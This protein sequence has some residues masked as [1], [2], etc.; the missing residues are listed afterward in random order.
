MCVQWFADPY[1]S[2]GVLMSAALSL[3]LAENLA[4]SWNGILID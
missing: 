1:L 3:V 4:P 2:S